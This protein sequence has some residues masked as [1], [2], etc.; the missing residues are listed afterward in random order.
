MDPWKES[1]WKTVASENEFV[2]LI[3]DDERTVCRALSRLLVGSI[4]QI[5]TAT[6]PTEAEIVLRSGRVTHILCD[7]WFGPG[8]P[9][10]MDLVTKWKKQYSTI[11]R[12]VVLTGTDINKLPP[13][14]GVDM[15]LP[16]VVEPSELIEALKLKKKDP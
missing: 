16:K 14:G 9:L 4:K 5:Q 1:F 2:L 15:V 6:T 12:A 13:T 8:Q 3:V 10:G 7:H 11:E